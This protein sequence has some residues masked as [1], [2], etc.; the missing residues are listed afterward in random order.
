MLVPI[1]SVSCNCKRSRCLKKY[2]ECVCAGVVCT[3]GGCKC[4]DC[5]NGKMEERGEDVDDKRSKAS[6]VDLNLP[7]PPP[8]IISG[9]SAG[10]G[11]AAKAAGTETDEKNNVGKRKRTK[12]G[13]R[14]VDDTKTHYIKKRQKRGKYRTKMQ[15][16]I[17][18]KD[19][20]IQRCKL[21]IVEQNKELERVKSLLQRFL[22]RENSLVSYSQ[23]TQESARSED[24]GSDDGS[25]DGGDGREKVRGGGGGGEEE[26]GFSQ[27][28]LTSQLSQMSELGDGAAL[29]DIM[30]I[31]DRV[32]NSQDDIM[33]DGIEES[34]DSEK[35]SA[36][37]AEEFTSKI[38]EGDSLRCVVDDGGT[39]RLRSFLNTSSEGKRL[40]SEFDATEK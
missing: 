26:G 7:S 25:G 11:A 5:E 36:G 1:E 23:L 8:P 33:S 32:D 21:F 40:L 20:A 2:C 38:D 30:H 24:A 34:D 19:E 28:I 39:S 37:H 3:V 27:L 12:N 14:E 17:R 22:D 13:S 35:T 6:A 29:N 10:T 9:P 31:I 16:A 15:Q 4:V 18:L